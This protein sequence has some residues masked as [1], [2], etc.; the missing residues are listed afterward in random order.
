[1][2]KHLLAAAVATAIAAPAMAQNV[3]VYGIID[4]AIQSYD[5]GTTSVTRSADGVLASS[6]LGFKGTEDLGGGL[7]ASFTLEQSV[8]PSTGSGTGYS[9]GAWVEL[10]GK[11]GAV[12]AGQGDTTTNQDIDSKV[13]Q[14]GNLALR[15]KVATSSSV[16][17]GELGGDQNNVFRYTLPKVNGLTVE[18]GYMSNASSDT[19]DGNDTITDIYLAYDVAGVKLHAGKATLDGTDKKSSTNFG[20]SYDAGFASFGYTVGTHDANIASGNIKNSVLSAKMPLGNGLSA[21]AVY[22]SAQINGTANTDSSGYTFAVTKALSKR[23]TVYGAYT[24][25]DVGSAAYFTMTGTT[26][27]TAVGQNHNALTL[28]V[29]HSF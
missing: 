19:A 3:S 7:K 14:A 23:T 21:H 4:T 18:L 1:M 22:A 11:F 10:S 15:P 27:G 2:K 13:S 9:R 5:A 17:N 12:R 16:S 20:A 25:T 24:K 29:A 6:R 26:A 8:T 28:G